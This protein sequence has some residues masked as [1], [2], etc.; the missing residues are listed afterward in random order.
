MG[1]KIE[2]RWWKEEHDGE[3]CLQWNAWVYSKFNGET[4]LGL[5]LGCLYNHGV[6]NLFLANES[7]SNCYISFLF[8]GPLMIPWLASE[9]K[10]ISGEMSSSEEKE[11]AGIPAWLETLSHIAS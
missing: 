5:L 11:I 9:G 6:F 3:Y 4:E 7:P 2:W 8:Q 1:G 10:V